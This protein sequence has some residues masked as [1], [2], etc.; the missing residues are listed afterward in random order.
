MD[1]KLSEMYGSR[2]WSEIHAALPGIT[3]FAI[4][5][6][7]QILGLRRWQQMTEAAGRI[8]LGEASEAEIGWL[9]GFLDGEGT[10][11]LSAVRRPQNGRLNYAPHV[12]IVNTS[13]AAIEKTR[14]LM[15]GRVAR[16]HDGVWSVRINGIGHIERLLTVLMPHL[17]VKTTRAEILM[18]YARL[19][20]S[21][22]GRAFYG[23][24]EH[25]LFDEF[26]FGRGRA[27][28]TRMPRKL[29]TYAD[30]ELTPLETADN[31]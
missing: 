13:H 9:A 12:T 11:G 26:Y 22:P 16:V 5:G 19:R 17:V 8:A 28:A 14:D 2:S 23:D 15:G 20:H 25:A 27:S 1:Q 7:A 31:A 10:M 21:R 18:E 29:R 6:R 4:Y 30:P 24:E 3:R